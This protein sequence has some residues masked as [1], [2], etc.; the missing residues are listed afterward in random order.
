MTRSLAIEFASRGVR[1]NAVAPGIIKTPM[2]PEA[3]HEALGQAPPGRPHG[4]AARYRRGGPLSRACALRDRR[5]P[6]RRRWP[7][8]RPLVEPAR[9]RRPTMTVYQ[10]LPAS[11]RGVAIERQPVARHA[12]RL[13]GQPRRHRACALRLHAALAGDCRR[14]LVRAVH[15]GLSSALPILPATWRARHSSGRSPRACRPHPRSTP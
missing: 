14:T 4:R 11:P 1:V 12:V 3:T 15:R 13:L 10:R 9:S 7:A 8:R 6:A 2:N 5:D